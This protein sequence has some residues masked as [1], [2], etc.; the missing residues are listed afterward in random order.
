MTVRILEKLR[1]GK[2]KWPFINF[3][4]TCPFNRNGTRE[5]NKCDDWVLFENPDWLVQ[6]LNKNGGVEVFVKKHGEHIEKPCNNFA[7]CSLAN[8][9]RFHHIE[10]YWRQC[11]VP[12]L[13]CIGICPSIETIEGLKKQ[14]ILTGSGKKPQFMLCNEK[15]NMEQTIIALTCPVNRDCARRKHHCDDKALFENQ[16]WL[17]EHFVNNGGKEAFQK[18]R[19]EFLDP[20]CD[21]YGECGLREKCSITHNRHHWEPCPVREMDCKGV[22][23]HL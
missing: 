22:C 20:L 6:H 23:A 12:H 11:P 21:A 7:N 18:R 17:V 14:K 15:Y 16:E 2:E 10:H 4:L 8:K 5:E 1:V 19:E 9:C 13:K 3:A